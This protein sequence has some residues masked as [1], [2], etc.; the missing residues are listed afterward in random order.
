MSNTRAQALG[1]L[2]DAMT[3]GHEG[4]T[5]RLEKGEQAKAVASQ[6]LPSRVHGRAQ[7]EALGFKFGDKVD[8]LFCQAIM[9]KG[10]TVIGTGHAMWNDILDQHGRRRGQYFYKGAFWD[11]EAFMNAPERR[12]CV[13]LDYSD[14][15]REPRDGIVTDGANGEVIHRSPSTDRWGDTGRAAALEWLTEHYPDHDS[16]AAYWDT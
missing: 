5:D 15:A 13:G 8:D 9:P 1:F 11:R 4:A 14:G 3:H 2:M 7:W 16:A 12:Y 10:W 6:H